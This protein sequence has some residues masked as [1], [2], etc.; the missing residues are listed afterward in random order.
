MNDY[1]I[2]AVSEDGSIR[3]FGC[4]S[5]TIADTARRYHGTSPVA[6][7]AIGRLLTAAS[8]MGAMLKGEEE[9]ITLQMTGSGPMGRVMAVGSPDGSVKGYVGQPLVDLP[10]NAQGKLDVGGAI[11]KDGFLTVITDL[12]LKEPF[13]GKIPLVSG[14]IGDDLAQYFA[15]SEQV[16]SVV[17]L[18]VLVDKD[19]SVKTSGGIIIQVMPGALDATLDILEENIKN[20]TSV[21]Q[22][23]DEG[24]SVEDILYVALRGIDYHITEKKDVQYKCNCSRERVSRVLASVGETELEAI[25]EEDGKAELCCQFCPE[26]YEFNKEELEAILEGIREEKRNAKESE[27]D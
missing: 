13:I 18:G 16:P 11:G 10:L 8:M 6:T 20:I 7:A 26:K 19:L 1:L 21:T 9:I 22:M 2:R 27:N 25:I 14:E 24:M 12:G 4:Y 3:A 23:L 15:V 17:A 5:K